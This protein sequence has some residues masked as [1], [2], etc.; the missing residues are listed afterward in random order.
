MRRIAEWKD[1][2]VLVEGSKKAVAII[3]LLSLVGGHLDAFVASSNILVMFILDKSSIDRKFII[4]PLS[5]S[6]RI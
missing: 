4:I 5:I 6:I 2:L 3:L 1:S